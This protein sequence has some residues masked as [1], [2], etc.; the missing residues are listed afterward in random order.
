MKRIFLPLLGATL[1]L[2]SAFVS[3]ITASNYSIQDGYSIEFK[4]KDPSGTFNVKGTIK[5]D[6][7][8]L[9]SSKFDL[10][11]PVSSISTGNGMK[12]KKAQTS[13]WFDAGKHPD[14]KYVSSKIEK[15][16][17]DYVVYGSLK[18]KGITKDKKVPLKVTKKGEGLVFSGSFQVNRMDYKVGKPSQAVPNVMNIDYSI[19]VKK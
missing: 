19:P 14:I 16:G 17:S 7:D 10:T 6:E 5:F 1:L 11:F 8:D 9:S 13:E 4:S 12:N 18:I 3:S 2:T 15:S